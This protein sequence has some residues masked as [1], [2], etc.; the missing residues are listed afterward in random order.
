MTTILVTSRSFGGGRAD[1]V[2]DLVGR[3]HHLVRG[4]SDHQLDALV[5]P[6]AAAD[7]WIAG[8]GPVTAAHLDAGPGLRVVARYG[9]GFDAVDV[10][11]ATS[12]GIAVT[13]TP[14][15]NTEAVADHAVGLMLAALRK[16][17]AGDRRVRQGEW[18]VV[19]RGHELGALTVGIVGFGRIGRGVAARL[20]GFGSVVLATDPMLTADELEAAG[21]SAASFDEL[22]ARCDLVTL[23]APG[24]RTLVD[25]R[26]LGRLARP[27]VL[28]NTARADLVDEPAL[29]TALREGRVA[30]YAADT[31]SDSS[32]AR[33]PLLD[34][35]L[36]DRV[37]VTPHA[38]AQ[39]WE[40]V[41]AMGRGAVEN[42]L[43]V[44]AGRRPPNLVNTW[45]PDPAGH[46]P[47][48]DERSGS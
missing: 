35:A 7:A 23:H 43:A 21:V 32:S 20:G 25:E 3:G 26:W 45:S 14:G 17:V 33:S 41:D 8:T 37:T 31:L 12:R 27:P 46:P 42:V 4:P 13:N 22:A 6:L 47:A 10:A 24:G 15:A 1:L 36:A 18:D 44:L 28:V 5:E 38:G 2:T 48:R 11:A 30:A 9:V 40:A 39:T 16:T 34:P 29:A 19:E